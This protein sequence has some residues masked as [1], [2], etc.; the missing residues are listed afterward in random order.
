MRRA[1]ADDDSLLVS[2]LVSPHEST[3]NSNGWLLFPEPLG[4]PPSTI[5]RSPHNMSLC[6]HTY[7][8]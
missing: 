6:L 7:A 8:N 4:G 1:V 5:T 2:Q 3:Y